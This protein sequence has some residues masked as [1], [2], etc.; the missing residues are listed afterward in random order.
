MPHLVTDS[1]S[2]TDHEADRVQDT[3][4]EK[5]SDTRFGASEGILTARQFIQKYRRAQT[6]GKE[7]SHTT[8]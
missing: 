8:S 3:T 7:R 1:T 6:Q 2:N 5:P 4:A